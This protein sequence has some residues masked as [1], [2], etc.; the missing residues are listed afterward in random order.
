MGVWEASFVPTW[1]K[2]HIK[3]G[4]DNGPSVFMESTFGVSSEETLARKKYH[5]QVVREYDTLLN[6]KGTKTILQGGEYSGL[7]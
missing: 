3:L 7:N 6:L 2:N 1:R 5:L 4:A